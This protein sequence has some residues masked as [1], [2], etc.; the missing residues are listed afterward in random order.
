M[1][2][3]M[4]LA[5][6]R[7]YDFL[8]PVAAR[9]VDRALELC[10]D[11]ATLVGDDA[12]KDM[13]ALCLSR[14]GVVYERPLMSRAVGR[15]GFADSL[16]LNGGDDGRAK[17]MRR[18]A[19]EVRDEVMADAGASLRD[20]L[21]LALDYENA[22]ADNFSQAMAEFLGRL[23]SRRGE[24]SKELLGGRPI[25]RIVGLS[26]SGAD[27]HCHGRMVMRVDTDAGTFFYKPHDCRL[28]ALFLE[29]V[30]T[31]LSGCARAA[32][33]VEG[34]GYAFVECLVPE[35]LATEGELRAY[36]H[37]LG[38]LTALFHGL[39]SR[40]M[41][42]DNLMCCGTCP[43]VLGLET[44][45]TG[46]MD[47]DGGM[48]RGN[49]ATEGISAGRLADSAVCTAVLPMRVGGMV[50]SPL[51]A[52]NPSGTCLP[53]V[54]GEPRTVRGCERDFSEGFERGYRHLM[55]H[56]DEVL[57]MVV[58]Y[59]EATCRQILVNTRA[60]YKARAL[61][62]SPGAMAD[63]SKR[64]EVLDGLGSSYGVFSAELREGVARPDAAALA[65]GDIPYYCS[66]ADSRALYAGEGQNV[67][68]L[69]AKSAIEVATDRL[70]R[71]SEEELRF[72]L[73]LIR[74]LVMADETTGGRP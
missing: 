62:F 72:E 47:F 21:P 28:D 59:G 30:G 63:P 39:G 20:R 31:W 34:N 74:R 54:A 45:L 2:W 29:L 68:D 73:D 70:S 65:E 23:L 3:A 58:R 32:R 15:V 53:R 8:E 66:R 50:V 52:D 56:R 17:V 38:R 41:T 13:L 16:A 19:G 6:T 40:D 35:E 36:W 11:A 71:L 55:C 37:N 24:V 44:L 10:L 69:L 42:R 14:L 27:P 43:A 25:T 22:V 4:A 7:C 64:D 9:A 18:I 57:E 46:A 60:Y 1:T 12:R 49:G 48:L 51:V 26:T 61:L 5:E 67:G 33:L